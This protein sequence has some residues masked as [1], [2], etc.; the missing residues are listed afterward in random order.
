MFESQGV[1]STKKK[2]DQTHNNQKKPTQGTLQKQS[3]AEDIPPHK[4][5]KNFTY[6]ISPSVK[7]TL[8]ILENSQSYLEAEMNTYLLRIIVIPTQFCKP[9][10]TM[11]NTRTGSEH[12]NP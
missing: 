6:G 5:T 1:I 3:E 2:K 7:S 10:L 9:P 12:T 4:K 11:E 8:M